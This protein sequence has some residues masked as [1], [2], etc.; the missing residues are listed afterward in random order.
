MT[1]LS[2]FQGSLPFPIDP[3]QHQSIEGLDKGS[4]TLLAAPTG[5]GKTVVAEFACW[6]ALHSKKKCFYTTPLKALSNQKFGD[7]IA[8]HSAADVG[9]LTGDNA[10]NSNAPLVVMTTEVLRNMLYEHSSA[11]DNLGWVVLDEVHYLQDRYRGAVWEEILIHLPRE[12]KVVCLSATVSNVAEFGDWLKQLRGSTEVVVESTRPVE[13]K[14]L[15]IVG[16]KFYELT[17]NTRINPMLNSVW[18]SQL[19]APPRRGREHTSGIPSRTEL[20]EMLGEAKMLPAICFIF[21]RVGCDRALEECAQSHIKLTNAQESARI[22]EFAEMR[23]TSIDDSDLEVLGFSNFVDALARGFGAHHAGMLPVFKETVEELFALGLVKLVFATETLAL[24]INMPAKTVVI[25]RLTKFTGERH[26]LLTPMDY[27]QLTGRAGRRG[28]DTLGHGV[29]LFSPWVPLE[30]VATLATVKSFPLTSSFRLSYNMAVNLVRNYDRERAIHMLN[31]SFAQFVRNRDVVSSEQ[32][33]IEKR[34]KSEEFTKQLQCEAGDIFEYAKLALS[35]REATSAERGSPAVRKAF[36]GLVAGDVIWPERLGKALVLEP[37]RSAAGHA[38]RLTLLTTDRKLRRVTARDFR[39]PPEVLAQL[40]L[41]GQSWR[42]PKVRRN[43]TRALESTHARRPASKSQGEVKQLISRRDSHPCHQCPEINEH[44]KIAS[45][46]H[47]TQAQA[48][49]LERRVSRRRDTLARSFERVL[50]LLRGQSYVEDWN[51][52]PKGELLRS[53]YNEADLL[54][55]ECLHRG[56]FSGLDPE[57]LASLMSV[58]T[59]QSRGRFESESAPTPHLSRYYRRITGLYS[60]IHTAELQLGLELLSEPDP[61]FMAA[62]FEWAGGADLEAVLEDREMS[63]GDFVRSTKQVIDLLQQLREVAESD[64]L[65]ETMRESVAA[66]Q[67]GV[68]AYSSLV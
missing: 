11:L 37:A 41:R 24:G 65:R 50:D 10:I 60:G 33:L 21:S 44:L 51:L 58:F 34:Q 57:E 31:S 27:T 6:L 26:E 68:V 46:L 29:V 53:V 52:T 49:A 59:Y 32:K 13:L 61:G 3:F 62:M 56:W 17:E 39:N 35:V 12:V 20:A 22:R 2:S 48:K 16:R 67:R 19:S 40:K 23:S 63:A 4:S 45:Q 38:P 55:I 42:S 1:D 5:S 54:V 64:D 7:L 14:N 8:R 30:K 66:I 9:L 18:N 47:R 43:L 28:I 15:A 25:E 36:G